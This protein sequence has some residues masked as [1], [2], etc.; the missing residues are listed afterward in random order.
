MMDVL[1]LS[2]PPA[3]WLEQYHRDGFYVV[4]GAL[5]ELGRAAL[6]Q[7]VMREPRTLEMLARL[8]EGHPDAAAQMTVRPWDTMCDRP[9][10]TAQDALLDAPLVR[11]ML[12]EVMG[13]LY[14]FCH[15]GFSLRTP[16]AHAATM[17]QDFAYGPAPYSAPYH[18][19]ESP[20]SVV[21]ILYCE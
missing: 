10:E 18:S 1:K 21:Q 20:Y 6:T 14:T 11:A 5:T 12:A 19:P 17:H 9:G 2:S 8:D 16:G 7:E 3:G 13:P 15:S 4:P